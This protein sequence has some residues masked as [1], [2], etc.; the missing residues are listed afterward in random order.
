[1]GNLFRTAQASTPRPA[2]CHYRD[3]GQLFLLFAHPW[4]A[5]RPLKGRAD[6]ETYKRNFSFHLGL[7]VAFL[8]EVA[9]MNFAGRAA[10]RLSVDEPMAPLPPP[11]DRWPGDVAAVADVGGLSF[12]LKL[13][14]KLLECF[15]SLSIWTGKLMRE[16]RRPSPL[17]AAG[18]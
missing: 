13:R 9:R 15:L 11:D 8:T 17:G 1:M 2:G 4:P 5:G 6:E 3:A 7:S 16:S 10:L 18:E 14:R 12:R